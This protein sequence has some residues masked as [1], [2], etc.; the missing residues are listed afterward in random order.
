MKIHSEE[1]IKKLK[2]P[3]NISLGNINGIK[4]VGKFPNSYPNIESK[5]LI[6]I[7]RP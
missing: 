5:S 3:I 4:Q 1:K 6:F 2:E 7:F